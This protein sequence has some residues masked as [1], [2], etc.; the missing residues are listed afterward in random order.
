MRV[1]VPM[2]PLFHKVFGKEW[3][4]LEPKQSIWTLVSA[5]ACVANIYKLKSS[6]TTNLEK[7]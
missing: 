4:F 6:E 5:S 2:I 7:L 3:G 1:L